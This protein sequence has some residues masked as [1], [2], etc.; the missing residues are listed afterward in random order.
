MG[1]AGGFLLIGSTRYDRHK[2]VLGVFLRHNLVYDL[3]NEKIVGE[4]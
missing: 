3:T 4:L 1:M 2:S